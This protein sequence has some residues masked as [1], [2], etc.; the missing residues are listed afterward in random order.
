MTLTVGDKVVY[1][2]Q[3][4]C[5]IGE[6]VEKIVAEKSIEVYR[7]ALLG[8]RGGELFVPV[9]KAQTIGVRP[10]LKKSEIPRLLGELM[11]TV[12]IAKDWRQRG[13]DIF[14]LFTSGSAFDLAEIIK[15]LT[16]LRVTKVLSFQENRTLEKAKRL[17]V[18]EISEVMGESESSAEERLDQILNARIIA[19]VSE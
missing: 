9:E 6:I 15:S 5:V 14:E 1:P 13:R 18:G 19:G 2:S 3:G 11:T 16:M 17:L 4:V 10:L 12:K 7:L 8:D